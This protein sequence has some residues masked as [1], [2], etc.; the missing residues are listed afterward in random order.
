VSGRASG[1]LHEVV[2]P[3]LV[4]AEHFLDLRLGLQRE[5]L[6]AAAAQMKHA[7]LA[8]AA[9]GGEHDRAGLVD[10]ALTSNASLLPSSAC[11]ATFIPIELSPG[12]D[13]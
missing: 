10:V 9:L 7:A 13:V 2:V 11:A 3:L 5:V 4:D 1:E 8:A 6:R 12:D